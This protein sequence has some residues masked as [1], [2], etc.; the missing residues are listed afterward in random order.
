[1]APATALLACEPACRVIALVESFM[2]TRQAMPWFIRKVL[3]WFAKCSTDALLPLSHKMM[4]VVINT[5]AHQSDWAGRVIDGKF[6]LLEWLGS[7]GWGVVFRTELQGFR[8]AVIRLI[9]A[10]V[11]AAQATLNEWTLATTFSHPHLMRVF[12]TGRCLIDRD[13]LLYMVTEYSEEAL[14]QALPERPLAPAE[15][16]EM[17]NPVLDALSYVHDKGLVY[18][19]LKPSDIMVVDDQ[20]KLPIDRLLRA[21]SFRKP[22]SAPQIYDAPETATGE[23]SQAANIWSL[24]VTLVEALTQHPPVWERSTNKDPV[25]PETIPEPFSNIARKCLQHDPLRRCTLSDIQ[26]LLNPARPL[27]V[28]GS[29]MDEEVRSK[30]PETDDDDRESPTSTRRVALM[31]GAVLVLLVV[32]GVLL[33]RSHKTPPSSSAEQQPAVTSEAPTQSPV[34]QAGTSKGT[35][36]KGEVSERV[37]PEV[38]PGANRTIRGKVEVR[39]RVT[40]SPSGEVSNAAF[41]SHGHSR[42]FANQALQAA[43]RWK[44]KAPHFDG[45]PVSSTWILRFV[46]TRNNTDVTPLQVS[47]QA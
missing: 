11:E 24:G 22:R 14:S 6:P 13:E 23:I 25:V 16:R 2:R 28:P 33:V 20:V 44:F 35:T 36:A 18:G 4:I 10:D 30:L 26:T 38:S 19:H 43:R 32:V 8:R 45:Q 39:V 1:M 27:P 34:P 31:V 21:G 5:A 40:V 3:N 46:F 42:Y 7:S 41:D 12:Q 37:L 9:P 29:K 15:A 47:P 17:L